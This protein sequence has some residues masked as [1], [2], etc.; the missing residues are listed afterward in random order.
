MPHAPCLSRVPDAWIA[1]PRRSFLA[2][3]ALLVAAS[4]ATA[5]APPASGIINGATTPSRLIYSDITLDDKW[6]ATGSGPQARLLLINADGTTTEVASGAGGQTGSNP[7]KY[8]ATFTA[9][10]GGGSGGGN[11]VLPVGSKYKVRWFLTAQKVNYPN[12]TQ[13]YSGSFYTGD[14]T[15][16]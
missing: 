1:L 15:M 6:T 14:F 3:A 5:Q 4:A 8:R 2:V 12:P 13:T 11:L 16:P 9:G 7:Q 10:A